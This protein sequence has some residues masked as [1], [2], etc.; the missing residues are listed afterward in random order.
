MPARQL[1]ETPSVGHSVSHNDLFIGM[2]GEA[3][4]CIIL[5]HDSHFSLMYGCLF[6][7]CIIYLVV[8]MVVQ[9]GTP[10]PAMCGDSVEL[11]KNCIIV[12]LAPSGSRVCSCIAL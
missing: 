4:L 6:H 7:Q 5:V 3:Q 9:D 12:L 10:L 8:Q 11:V 2:M 1:R